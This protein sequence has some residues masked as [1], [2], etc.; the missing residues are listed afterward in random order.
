M[1]RWILEVQGELASPG[2][3][4][5]LVKECKGQ[6]QVSEVALEESEVAVKTQVP[7]GPGRAA[8][9]PIG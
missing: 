6:T 4:T 2:Q 7:E 3:N 5:H 9:T 8:S 1:W